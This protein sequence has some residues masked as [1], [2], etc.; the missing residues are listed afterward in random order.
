MIKQNYL[1]PN[2]KRNLLFIQYINRMPDFKELSKKYKL[3]LD[4]SDYHTEKKWFE[5]PKDRMTGDVSIKM[6][7]KDGRN[8]GFDLFFVDKKGELYIRYFSYYY[9]GDR[10]YLT[11]Y[12]KYNNNIVRNLSKIIEKFLIVFEF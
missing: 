10:D 4:L 2:K 6:K 8:T 7:L 3:K 9:N 11:G 5:S 12:L 1:R